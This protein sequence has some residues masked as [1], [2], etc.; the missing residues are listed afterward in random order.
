MQV[1]TMTAAIDTAAARDAFWHDWVR[2]YRR[3]GHVTVPALFAP[4]LMQGA[5]ADAM[6]WSATFLDE[7]D[8][9]KRAWYLD[10]AA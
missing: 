8:E 10:T 4:V 7:L 1:E 5:I 3:D 2:R 9:A 6:A